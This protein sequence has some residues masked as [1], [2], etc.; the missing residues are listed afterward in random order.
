MKED[1]TADPALTE[2]ESRGYEADPLAIEPKSPRK[3]P[4]IKN[5]ASGRKAKP[6][7][8]DSSPT[9]G[10]GNSKRGNKGQQ[11]ERQHEPV[12]TMLGKSTDVVR[13]RQ[14]RYHT[15]AYGLNSRLVLTACPPVLSPAATHLSGRRP[16]ET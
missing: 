13:Y 12:A 3:K 5:L 15:A 14:F 16:P 2:E 11:I 1:D 9:A 10:R 7:P 4:M 6:G 8:A